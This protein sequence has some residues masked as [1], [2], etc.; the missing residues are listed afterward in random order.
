MMSMVIS[1]TSDLNTSDYHQITTTHVVSHHIT[2][3]AANSKDIQAAFTCSNSVNT[4]KEKQIKIK[5]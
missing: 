4:W 5:E 1:S 2:S 3:T